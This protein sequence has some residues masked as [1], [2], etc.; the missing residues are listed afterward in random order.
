MIIACQNSSSKTNRKA[1]NQSTVPDHS[2]N[3][4][5]ADSSIGN[6]EETTL[7]GTSFFENKVIK[8]FQN[9][10]RCHAPD[11][12]P[13]ERDRG[14]MTIYQYK[15]MLNMLSEN[16]LLPML[17]GT[18]ENRPHPNRDPCISGINSS[19]CQEIA[20]WWDIEFG[21]IASKQSE[22]PLSTAG[23]ITEVTADGY[24][25]GWAINPQNLT[26]QVS[27]EIAIN[28]PNFNEP[29]TNVANQD[30]FDNGNPG[31]HG[32][33]FLLPSKW[34]DGQRYQLTARIALDLEYIPITEAPLSFIALP[35][36]AANSVLRQYFN[37]N[38]LPTMM[39]DCGCHGNGLTYDFLW[40]RLLEPFP[41][42][43]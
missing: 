33:R 10:Q 18:L 22:R 29:L 41:S 36:P 15:P 7:D 39:T 20:N 5:D 24:I 42:E 3:D 26:T 11:D 37:S 27:I 9:C 43:G 8:A 38:V 16:T 30:L 40:Q 1:T 4:L 17:R 34:L 21:D 6:P 32:F 35:K 23:A 31:S 28:D 12:H 14:P 2:N 13:V 19:P 25:I